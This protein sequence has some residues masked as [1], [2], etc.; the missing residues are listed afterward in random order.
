MNI[1]F[2][3]YLGKFVLAY[4]DDILVLSKN[5]EDHKLH[6]KKVFKFFKNANYM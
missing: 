4:L 5:G 1:F 6:M 3:K 2:H